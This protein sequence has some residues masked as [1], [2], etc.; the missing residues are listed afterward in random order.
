[1]SM[2]LIIIYRTPTTTNELLPAEQQN[3]YHKFATEQFIE[4]DIILYY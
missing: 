1:M 3:G 4:G 2:S